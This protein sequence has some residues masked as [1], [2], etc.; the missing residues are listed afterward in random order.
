MTSNITH[1]EGDDHYYVAGYSVEDDPYVYPN[2]VLINLLNIQDTATL[3][4]AE[5]DFASVRIIQLQEEPIE[6][7]FS[8]ST[9]RL[10]IGSCS[11]IFT[12]GQVSVA[13][14]ISPR[15]T[16]YSSHTKKLNS[17]STICGFASS[18][19]IFCLT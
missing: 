9:Y 8:L 15:T 18:K 13:K 16:L 14:S 19:L 10:F 7:D 1:D 12:L 3:G 17:L 2:G 4:E 5:T 11:K 6:G